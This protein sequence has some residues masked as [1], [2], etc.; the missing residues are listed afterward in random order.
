MFGELLEAGLFVWIV[1][2]YGNR[3][4]VRV[5]NSEEKEKLLARNRALK[6]KLKK[7]TKGNFRKKV[8]KR[9]KKQ[10]SLWDY[11]Q[12]VH[13]L[14]NKNIEGRN[15]MP[16]IEQLTKQASKRWDKR[17]AKAK[18]SVAK[19]EKGKKTRKGG[20]SRFADE[21]YYLDTT[22]KNR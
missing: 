12:F 14:S 4:R 21:I 2:K 7:K 3:K 18:K 22:S 17:T 6:A 19:M 10:K 8:I 16:T 5:K 13:C 9:V 20:W 15:K 11:K 1:D